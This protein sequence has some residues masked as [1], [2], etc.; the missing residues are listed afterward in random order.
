M[1]WPPPSTV[2]STT[3]V[4]AGVG[5]GRPSESGGVVDQLPPLPAMRRLVLVAS[6]LP[7]LGIVG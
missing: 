2:E 6:G 7:F 5:E 3:G 4:D 1:V